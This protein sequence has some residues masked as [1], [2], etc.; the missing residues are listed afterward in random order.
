MLDQ[1]AEDAQLNPARICGYTH[2]EWEIWFLRYEIKR[3]NSENSTLTEEIK[4]LNKTTTSEKQ[5]VAI[6]KNLAA[7]IHA[8]CVE[9]ALKLYSIDSDEWSKAQSIAQKPEVKEIRESKAFKDHNRCE[10]NYGLDT[11]ELNLLEMA[12][13]HKPLARIKMGLAKAIMFPQDGMLMAI[14]KGYE[15]SSGDSLWNSVEFNPQAMLKALKPMTLDI[16]YGGMRRGFFRAEAKRQG[17]TGPC[18]VPKKSDY[19]GA[20]QKALFVN[21]WTHLN[22][23]GAFKRALDKFIGVNTKI[24]KILERTLLINSGFHRMLVAREF[25]FLL[26]AFPTN[27]GSIIVNVGGGAAKIIR[28]F[29]RKHYKKGVSYNQVE[30][31]EDLATLHE[32]LLKEL[33][34]NFIETICPKGWLIDFTEHACCERRRYEDAV[35]QVNAGKMPKRRRDKANALERQT[36]RCHRLRVCWQVLGFKALPS[37]AVE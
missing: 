35:A 2:D 25:G 8:S 1:R 15:E 31:L 3:L 30:L 33:D 27:G 13:P 12:L 24:N 20:K 29:M 10:P 14:E 19:N 26:E 34:L 5:D 16:A 36:V 22:N 37:R 17:S 9:T 32:V 28:T 4:K 7:Y 21:Y 23:N 11:G 6:T 18:A